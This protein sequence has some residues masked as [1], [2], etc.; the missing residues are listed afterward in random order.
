MAF[1]IVLFRAALFL[2]VLPLAAYAVADIFLPRR[3]LV[4]PI[5]G[6]FDLG[7][8]VASIVFIVGFLIWAQR[9]V[10]ERSPPDDTPDGGADFDPEN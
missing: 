1:L 2:I 6:E 4:V 3:G 8:L 5:A 7:V 9:P 10:G